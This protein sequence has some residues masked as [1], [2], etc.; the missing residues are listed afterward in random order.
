MIVKV[1]NGKESWSYFEC[2]VI[3]SKF[4]SLENRKDRNE[5]VILFE[6]QPIKD[7]LGSK[8]VKIL[9]LELLKGHLRTII[10]DRPVY[11]LNNQG[12]TIDRI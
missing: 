3:H 7:N 9:S 1:K 10:T 5:D 4:D 6:M 12:K 8:Q 11:V 2:E